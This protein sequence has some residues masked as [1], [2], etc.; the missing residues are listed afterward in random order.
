M[1][2]RTLVGLAIGLIIIG[3]VAT[4]ATI[5]AWRRDTTSAAIR[6]ISNISTVLAEQTSRSV[7]SIDLVLSDTVDKLQAMGAISS[8][9][10]R[11][12]AHSK[13]VYDILIDRLQHL[14]QAT[15]ISLSDNTGALLNTTRSWPPPLLNLTNR[16][17]FL[18]AKGNRDRNLYIA[19]PV[20]SLVSDISTIY[21]SRRIESRDGE[22]LG[23]IVAGSEVSYFRHIYDSIQSFP[24][25]AFT[26]LR[27]DGTF[28]V[29]HPIGK[30]SDV[31]KMPIDSPWYRVVS[32]GGGSYRSVGVFGGNP[33]LVAVRPLRDYPL[34]VDVSIDEAQA[35]APW[36]RRAIFIAVGSLLM[37]I[38]SVL[39]VK[40]LTSQF[41]RLKQSE[42]SLAE[43]EA[44]LAEKSSQLEVAHMQIDAALNNIPQGLLMFDAAARLVVINERYI[45][46]YGLSRD[47]V[48]PGCSLR[49]LIQ[50]RKDVGLFKGDPEQYCS[51]ILKTIAAGKAAGQL[52]ETTDGR[53]IYAVQQPLADGGWVVTH[54][55]IT[56]RK[57]AEE[58][59]AFMARHDALTGLANR[60]LLHE[61]MEE[62]LVRLRRRGE[63]FSLFVFDLDLFK[64]VNDSL[65][66]PIGDL[67]LTAVAQRLR[68]CTRET[69][70]VARLG[71]DE[72]AL[73]QSVEGN[74][75][76]AA[77]A[78]ATRLL[79]AINAPYEV[80]G[81]PILIGASIGIVLAPND[82]LEVEQ[83]LKNADLALYRAKA[84]GRNGFRLFEPAMDA[85]ARSRHSL[86]VDLRASIGRDEFEILYQTVF[87]A[88]TREPR[89][90]EALVRW[91]HPARGVVEPDQFIPVAEEIG[92]ILPLGERVLRRACA[93]AAT[94]PADI[95]VAVNLSPLQFRTG[96][97]VE[98]IM[99]ALADSGLPASRL[100]LEI[101]E[102]VLLQKNAANLS[103]LHEL[104]SLGVS[105]V[106]DDFGTGYS[107][108]SYLRTFP[109]DKIKIDKSFVH[110]LTMR[111]ECAA[112]VDAVTALGRGLNMITTAEG[113]ETEEQF[114]LL[115]AAGVD[116][117]QGYLFSHPC[118]VSQLAFEHRR[119]AAKGGRAA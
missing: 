67:L 98:T 33:R 107:S 85:E 105:I 13:E 114:A 116:H 35:L 18:H 106:L 34:V 59:M 29:R 79:D 99:S 119:I 96:Q 44:M 117:V 36:W 74:Q 3:M 25:L 82:G 72:F 26:L 80:E 48:K 97:L 110:E 92:L 77:L 83:L 23:I 62:A 60:V 2:F 109:F 63:A 69:D 38:C 9:G 64:S 86:Q 7:Q 65:G 84:E 28:L 56:E 16:D 88:A 81:H 22:F 103:T 55:D 10:F 54:D 45:E 118:L 50:H 71:G 12:V 111:P 100:E 108:L 15:V 11:R 32:Q 46:M 39:L 61:K 21:W 73:L 68:S 8:D 4:A 70:T 14:S 58:K 1:T 101:T 93:D 31:S 53:T 75:R 102:S 6:D 30:D 49:T 19:G 57:R 78:L 66:H 104:R 87:D 40:A 90:V 47:V 112:I 43:R 95:K 51:Q 24:G 89:S 27:D 91:C 76:D 41:H 20:L 113:V 52:I 42:A 115:R 5:W 37:V 94:W 17:H